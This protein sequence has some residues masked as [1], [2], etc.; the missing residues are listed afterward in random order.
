MPTAPRRDQTVRREEIARLTPQTATPEAVQELDTPTE[1][2]VAAVVNDD[3]LP[4]V[5]SKS[6]RSSDDEI[7]TQQELNDTLVD[8]VDQSKIDALLDNVRIRILDENAAPETFEDCRRLGDETETNIAAEEQM[9]DGTLLD[10]L[11]VSANSGSAPLRRPRAARFGSFGNAE[12]ESGISSIGSRTIKT[13][14]P[15]P[16]DLEAL[17]KIIEDAKKQ[18]PATEPEREVAA[19]SL[20]LQQSLQSESEE[21]RA[22]AAFQVVANASAAL[23]LRFIAG[24]SHSLFNGDVSI[25]YS[26]KV[27]ARSNVTVDVALSRR[28]A[29]VR[30]A[31]IVRSGR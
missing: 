26:G 3:C 29:P 18:A 7:S 10:A 8:N 23:G 2:N 25:S 4:P 28:A 22:K 16:E 27:G 21:E 9:E 11:S 20:D 30:T 19:L 17:N 12:A 1:E 15:I 14:L 24:T 31:P 5:E 6:I 13:R